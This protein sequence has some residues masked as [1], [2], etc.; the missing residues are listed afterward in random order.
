MRM[1]WVIIAVMLAGCVTDAPP[2]KPFAEM[3]AGERCAKMMKMMGNDNFNSVQKMA[4]YEKA[5]NEGCLG[6]SQPQTVVVR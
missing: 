6:P 3:T 2:E 4:L 5:R 1:A